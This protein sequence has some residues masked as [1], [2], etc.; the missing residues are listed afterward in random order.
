MGK[1][2][3]VLGGIVA[4]ALGI[5]NLMRWWDEVTIVAKA[6]LVAI[7]IFGGLLAFFAGVGEIKDSS[8]QKQEEE[9]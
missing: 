6:A 5:L 8:A 4:V 7:L 3:S 9:K 2:L 1:Y